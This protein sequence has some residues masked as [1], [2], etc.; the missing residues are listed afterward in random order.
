VK[1]ARHHAL[2]AIDV[3]ICEALLTGCFAGDDDGDDIPPFSDVGS[4]WVEPLLAVTAGRS[5]I[6]AAPENG[7][8]TASRVTGS[9]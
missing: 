3:A 8:A 4:A 2:I 5:S 6:D 9:R 1:G 7:Q